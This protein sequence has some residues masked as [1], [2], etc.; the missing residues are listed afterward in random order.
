MIFLVVFCS[1]C[2][3][4]VFFADIALQCDVTQSL[5]TVV[6]DCDF[7]I[8]VDTISCSFDGAIAEPCKL[9]TFFYCSLPAH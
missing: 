6:L 5:A 1:W 3:H 2:L 4:Q 9:T 8:V 7:N